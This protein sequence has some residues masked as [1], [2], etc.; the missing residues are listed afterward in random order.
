[1]FAREHGQ[2]W[3]SQLLVPL[4]VT[5]SCLRRCLAPV[6]QGAELSCGQS[7]R[8]PR[9]GLC[10]ALGP[11]AFCASSQSGPLSSA[12]FVCVLECDRRGKS[13]PG[14]LWR[15]TDSSEEQGLP[16]HPAAVPRLRW[17]GLHR[18]SLQ[19][20]TQRS[21]HAKEELAFCCGRHQPW[22]QALW[23]T[24]GHRVRGAEPSSSPALEDPRGE[25]AAVSESTA[26]LCLP[27]LCCGT[28]TAGRTRHRR[29]LGEIQRSWPESCGTLLPV[30]SPASLS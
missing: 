27:I 11:A 24:R 21:S 9:V 26:T 12:A 1:M 15:G 2:S 25:C 10:S 16:P 7:P 5:A 18:A 23:H 29:C 14:G 30:P 28:G 8:E 3:G 17:H 19:P 13:S 22:Q 20:R 4:V 6:A